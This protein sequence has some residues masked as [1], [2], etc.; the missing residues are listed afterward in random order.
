MATQDDQRREEPYLIRLR[1]RSKTLHISQG[2]SVLE[3]D[4]DGLIPPG[5]G[6]G[7]YVHQTRLLSKYFYLI[8]DE[9]PQLIA[10]SNVRQHSFLG[11]YA[12]FPPGQ[13][14]SEK[15]LGSGEMED[16]SEHTLEL[17]VSRYVGGGLH[18]DIDLTNFTQKETRFTF[19]VVIDADFIDRSELHIGRQQRGDLKTEWRAN[20]QGVWGLSFDY[21]VRHSYDHQ[22]N[23]GV[24]ELHRGITIR[25]SNAGSQPRFRRHKLSFEVAL[26]PHGSW[27]TCLD[28]TPR[29]EDQILEPMY[30]CRS[31]HQQRIGNERSTELLVRESTGF[32]YATDQT[33][34]PV[35]AEALETAKEDLAAMRLHDLDRGERAWTI[36]AGLPIYVSLFGRDTL[37]ASWQAA[38][39]GT[40][41]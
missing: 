33:L 15:D 4:S 10:V 31:F 30:G 34:T 18:E 9:A 38:I 26:P 22:G 5:T 41:R 1:P 17:R 3:T 6:Y 28:F 19:S 7:F 29:I 24:A 16:I 23:S 25:V 36:A 2:R 35:V 14:R 21:D 27:H 12:I 40:G 37:T 20:D 8:D 11:Y 39:L 32:R 13:E